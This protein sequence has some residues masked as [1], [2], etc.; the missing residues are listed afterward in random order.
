[1][2]HFA[3]RVNPRTRKGPS[4]RDD[5]S[6]SDNPSSCNRNA[7]APEMTPA[8]PEMPYQTPDPSWTMGLSNFYS[9]F[10]IVG[11]RDYL[12]YFMKIRRTFLKFRK[13]IVEK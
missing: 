10:P 1:M 5:L 13:L 7:P 12:P 2:S 8:V 11:Y 9:I 4:S 3:T 6:T